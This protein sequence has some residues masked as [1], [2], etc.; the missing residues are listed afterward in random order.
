MKYFGLFNSI[1][2]NK[3][4]PYLC[5]IISFIFS[6]LV[7]GMTALTKFLFNA[8]Y[9]HIVDFVEQAGIVVCL[10]FLVM[11]QNKN[12]TRVT[13]ALIGELLGIISLLNV[14]FSIEATLAY[15]PLANTSFIIYV[16]LAL[17]WILTAFCIII[18]V[19]H[20][21]TNSKRFS[22][23]K[24]IAFNQIVITIQ[25]L[26]IA[27]IVIFLV[28]GLFIV[29]DIESILLIVSALLSACM[30]YAFLTAIISMEVQEHKTKVPKK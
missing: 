11:V 9:V 28:M 13:D 5:F 24:I 18:C 8:H 10:V 2:T 30:G 19:N 7:L 14:T 15:A 25:L 21:L 4:T 26:I 3:K 29:A 1:Y 17:Q 16:M 23:S 27:I 20:Y 6:I 12:E 22:K